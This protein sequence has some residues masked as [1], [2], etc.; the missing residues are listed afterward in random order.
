MYFFLVVFLN[1]TSF[2]WY[3][4]LL[5]C[6]LVY[7]QI[8]LNY[9]HYY[10]P[11]LR[12]CFSCCSI[13]F[14]C[15]T[16]CLLKD[17]KKKY[18]PPIPTRVGKRKKKTKGPDAASKLPLGKKLVLVKVSWLDLI[19]LAVVILYLPSEEIVFPLKQLIN[20]GFQKVITVHVSPNS[21]LTVGYHKTVFTH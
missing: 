17:K 11:V 15:V 13:F 16:L 21:Q 4:Y 20:S 6:L 14:S 12:V 8:L 1:L 3:V 19:D 10:K 7:L 5:P 18:E 9:G 2:N